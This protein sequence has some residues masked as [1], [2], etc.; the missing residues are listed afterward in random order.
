MKPWTGK[1]TVTVTDH[2]GL[3]HPS[4]GWVAAIAIAKAWRRAKYPTTA[5]ARLGK[6][7]VTS[8]EKP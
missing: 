7:T 3:H 6:V 4:L 1:L 2:L 5:H 8:R